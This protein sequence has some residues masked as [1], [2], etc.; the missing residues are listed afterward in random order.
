MAETA[1]S[2]GH[3]Q[4]LQKIEAASEHS[5]VEF[6]SPSAALTTTMPVGSARSVSWVL[7][8]LI[9]GLLAAASLI[10]MDVWVTA[11]GRVISTAD[12]IIIQ[13]YDPSIIRSINVREGQIV[14]A[15]DVLARLDPTFAGSDEDQ[16]KGQVETY[17]AMVDE[18]TAEMNRVAY[19]PKVAN[20]ATAIQAALYGERMAQY[21]ATVEGY[22]QKIAALQAT[23]AQSQADIQGYQMR[24]QLAGQLEDIRVKLEKMQVGSAID[25]L[26]AQDQR[27]EMARQLANAVATSQQATANIKEMAQERETFD[28]Q[29]FAQLGQNL[30]DAQRNLNDSLQNYNKAHLRRQI[31][32]MKAPAD[33]VVLSIAKVSTGAVL[34]PSTQLM[35]LAP[36][37]SPM[38]VD[39]MVAGQDASWV[40]PGQSTLIQFNAFPYIR[41]GGGLGTVRLQ[42]ADSFTTISTDTQVGSSQMSQ[43]SPAMPFYDARITID[44]VTMHGIPGG[45]HLRPGLPVTAQIRT[46]TRTVMQ[47]LLQRVLTTWDE[48]LR[49]P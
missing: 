44:Q 36:L 46:A 35:Q 32:D 45:F 43:G 23:L 37:D 34:Q 25:R 20:T 9:L 40:H 42:S 41:Y 39:V 47:Y 31:V 2:S 14:R 26:S 24:L 8:F 10:P 11:T 27:T 16:Y 48:S 6:E 7:A 29:W 4:Q 17:Q 13:P 38:E 15:G 3:R 12:T 5:L 21:R 18:M 1:I 19:Q 33:A 22:N 30:T 28:K 49:E